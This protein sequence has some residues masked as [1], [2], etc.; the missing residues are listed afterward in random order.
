MI[1]RGRLIAAVAFALLAGHAA[2]AQEHSETQREAR[3]GA[4]FEIALPANPSTGYGWRV[5]EASSVGLQ[6]VAIEDRGASSPASKAERPIV[7]APVLHTW[8]VTPRQRGSVR[9]V[10]DYG[11]PWETGP[12]AK[13]H[14]FLIDIA[15]SGA[16][17]H[18]LRTRV[19]ARRAGDIAALRSSCNRAAS[20]RRQNA[21]ACPGDLP[22]RMPHLCQ[23]ET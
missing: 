10:L 1:V 13:T 3:V 11:R 22:R 2:T 18:E 17:T 20:I 8:L 7:G 23:K 6:H 5:N 12:P 14:V 15:G 4:P 21:L 16:P 9:L 19:A